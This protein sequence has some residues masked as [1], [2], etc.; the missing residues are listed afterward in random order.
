MKG[1]CDAT[2]VPDEVLVGQ[3]QMLNPDVMNDSGSETSALRL[4]G[5]G[6][7]ILPHA[8]QVRHRQRIVR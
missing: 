4:P 7:E 8:P 2:L 6:L 5:R 1:V 3:L